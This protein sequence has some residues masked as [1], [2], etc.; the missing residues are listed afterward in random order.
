MP[1]SNFSKFE[2][3]SNTRSSKFWKSYFL[4]NIK[5][6]STRVKKKTYVWYHNFFT[7]KREIFKINFFITFYLVAVITF[8]ARFG[9]N[10]LCLL[11]YPILSKIEGPFWSPNPATHPLGQHA[12]VFIRSEKILKMLMTVD[13]GLPGEF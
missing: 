6:C 11:I 9:I 13:Y 7:L 2:Y 3:P 8:E 12:A 4:T 1:S 5:T 10:I